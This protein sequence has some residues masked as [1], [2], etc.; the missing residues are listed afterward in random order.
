VTE[1]SIALEKPVWT[2]SEQLEAL[3]NITEHDFIGYAAQLFDKVYLKCLAHGNIDHQ[4]AVSYTWKVVNGL[5][6]KLAEIGPLAQR[7]HLQ[8]GDNYV[9]RMKGLSD[10]D[11]NSAIKIVYQVNS[12]ISCHIS[13]YEYYHY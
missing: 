13:L 7:V 12:W 5:G 1:C 2:I 11:T 10:T 8:P 4:Q 9:Y 3:M 6:L